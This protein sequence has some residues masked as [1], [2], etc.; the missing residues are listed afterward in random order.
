MRLQNFCIIGLV[1]WYI[2]LFN[3]GLALLGTA[4][5]QEIYLYLRYM[6]III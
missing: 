2:G 4:E 1:H 5:T 3:R 6:Y